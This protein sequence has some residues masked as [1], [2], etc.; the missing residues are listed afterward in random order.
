MKRGIV[1]AAVLLAVTAVAQAEDQKKLGWSDVAEFSF[2]MTGGNT[3]T[4]TFGF[5]NALRRDWERAAFTLRA[6]AVRA[7]S[8][9]VTRAAFVDGDGFNI[10]ED[11]KTDTTA[12]FYF[13][14]GQYDRNVTDKFYWFVG[15]GWERNEPAGISNR[16]IASAGVGNIWHNTDDLKF[17]TFYGLTWTN[18]KPVVGESDSY[19][20][21]RGGY[22]YFNKLTASTTMGSLLVIDLNGSETSDWRAD[23][24]NWV[25]V[26]INQ[27][28]AL[29]AS[30]QLLYDNQPAVRSVDLYDQIPT[31]EIDLDGYEKVG[32][33][34]QELDEL[35][36]IF[37]TSLVITW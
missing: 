7:E 26:S 4:S 24:T 16:Y 25:A 17:K 22:D 36:T 23:W 10:V 2:V 15:A 28:M 8:D 31:R 34:Q 33:V 32:T 6:G 20:G 30:L 11:T 9:T 14:N 5:K 19:V 13:L 21:V 27:R 12:E 18:E 3:T 1:A 29:K 35:D 37:T